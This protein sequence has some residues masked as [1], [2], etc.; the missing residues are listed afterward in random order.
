MRK[1]L[2]NR[3]AQSAGPGSEQVTRVIAKAQGEL[4]LCTVSFGGEALLFVPKIE[5]ETLA[6]FLLVKYDAYHSRSMD[7]HLAVSKMTPF[8]DVFG[9]LW[10]PFGALWGP[11]GDPF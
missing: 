5:G 1:G 10:G 2:I 7:C 8:W 4:S 9:T 3:F 6:D 11:F